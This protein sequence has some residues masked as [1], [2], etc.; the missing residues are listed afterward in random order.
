MISNQVHFFHPHISVHFSSHSSCSILFHW[1]HTLVDC[2]CPFHDF[3]SFLTKIGCQRD[4]CGC[5]CSTSVGRVALDWPSFCLSLFNPPSILFPWFVRRN[6][7]KKGTYL[8]RLGPHT[9]GPSCYHLVAKK[10]LCQR[11]SGAS[12]WSIQWL[13]RDQIIFSNWLLLWSGLWNI[14]Q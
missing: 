5:A 14:G 8:I 7:R 12:K 2:T 4:F 11:W 3:S 10:S 1:P 9:R 6:W 13:M